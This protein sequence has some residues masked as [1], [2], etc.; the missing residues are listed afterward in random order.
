MSKLPPNSMAHSIMLLLVAI[1]SPASISHAQEASEQPQKAEKEEI[2]FLTKL[3]AQEQLQKSVGDLR[4]KHQ[5]PALWAG[6]FYADGRSLLA[7]TGVR[8][9][10]EDTVVENDDPIHIG[11]CTKAMTAVMIA[12]LCSRGALT[13]ETTLAEVFANTAG[14]AES[15]W[16]RV[17]VVELLQHRS[18]APANPNWT[19][20]HREHPDD[21]VAAREAMLLWLTTQSKVDK[22]KYLYSNVGYALLGHIVETIEHEPWELLIKKRIFDPLEIHSAGHG[23]VGSPDDEESVEK[24]WGHVVSPGLTDMLNA[25][26]KKR[27]VPN[28]VP[29][30]LDNLPPLGPAG[31]LHMNVSDWS[32]FV[33]LFADEQGC[34]KVG[35]KPGVWSALLQADEGG[36]YA[37]GWIKMER[38]W[39]GGP[40]LYHNG[41]NT[42]WYCIV[43]VV[44]KKGFCVMAAANVFSTASIKAC[45]DA[46]WEAAKFDF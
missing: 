5:L 7:S 9:W 37:G 23:P 43:F 4:E 32:K 8:K 33:L 35:V 45:G 14:L 31:R 22:P 13:F 12:Q 17:T 2:K 3:E 27:S 44:P 16:G 19:K 36:D 29:V 26:L 6:K 42:T 34:E 20:L 18:G 21:A 46:V 1:H 25:V 11:S 10:N 41:S 24:P 38:K 30:Q 15:P 28:Y 39:A 40:V